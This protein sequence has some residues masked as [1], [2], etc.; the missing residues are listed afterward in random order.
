MEE[1]KKR[2]RGRPTRSKNKMTNNIVT[3]TS[4]PIVV[5]KQKSVSDSC[6]ICDVC[7]YRINSISQ[8]DR[9]TNS[10]LTVVGYC[11]ECEAAINCTSLIHI[12]AVYNYPKNLPLLLTDQI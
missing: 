5:K 10:G 7:G 12:K 3:V 8:F 4:N 6:I 9:L 2:G 11:P 1:T